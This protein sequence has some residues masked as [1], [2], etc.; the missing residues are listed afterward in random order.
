[1]VAVWA[2]NVRSLS[3]TWDLF[4]RFD[5]AG[6]DLQ[7]GF[8]TMALAS[9]SPVQGDEEVPEGEAWDM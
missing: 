2:P 9:S 8:A 3:R 4:E 1:M 7:R 6:R 5:R